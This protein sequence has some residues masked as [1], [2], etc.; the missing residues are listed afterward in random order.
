MNAVSQLGERVLPEIV[1]IL[2]RGLRS[3]RAD[4][5]QGVCIGL[6]EILASTSRDAVLSFADGLVPTVRTALCDPL[7]EVRMAA[8][9]T[10]DSLHATI[11]NKALDDILP[12][13][14]E[15]LKDPDPEIAEATLDGLKQVCLSS[16]IY[17]H[18]L[19]ITFI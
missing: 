7:P 3:E 5:R 18:S 11:G 9:R 2:E 8:A 14:L 13:M 6:G 19:D 1:P 12:Q 17:N 16:F 15:G 4:Q 10:F